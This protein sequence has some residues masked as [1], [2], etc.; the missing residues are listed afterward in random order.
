MLKLPDTNANSKNKESKATCRKRSLYIYI[1]KFKQ[2]G[3]T[4][5]IHSGGVSGGGQTC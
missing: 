5:Y 3:S 4:E 1:D 2:A